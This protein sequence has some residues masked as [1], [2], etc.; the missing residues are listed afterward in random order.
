MKGYDNK[1]LI[2][3]W[4]QNEDSIEDDRSEIENNNTLDVDIRIYLMVK[5]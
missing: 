3:K 2:V 1:L 4:Q 5:K